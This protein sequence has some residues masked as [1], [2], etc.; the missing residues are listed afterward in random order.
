MPSANQVSIFDI[1][2]PSVVPV[3]AR[4]QTFHPRFGWLKK[5][6]DTVKTDS[7]VF[8]KKNSPVVLG[9]GKNMVDAIK[10]W[11]IA[12]KLIQDNGERLGK[13]ITTD[14]GEQL[15]GEDGWDPY[16]EDPASLW[17]LHWYLL[18]PTSH[19]T[20]WYLL[21]NRFNQLEF[22]SDDITAALEKSRQDLFPN[23]K[24]AKGSLVKDANCILRMYAIQKEKEVNEDSID[25]PFVNLGLIEKIDG[26]RD[27]M[28]N[29]GQHPQLAPEI[30]VAVCL[31]YAAMVESAK[32]ISISRLLYDPGCPGVAFKLT[33][34]V[35]SAAI[36][37]VQSEF[38]SIQ[39]SDSSGLI[40]FSF[41]GDPTELSKQILDKYFGNR[42]FR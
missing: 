3:F 26:S 25:C 10:Y 36:E 1:N 29:V 9:V 13:Y 19:A 18:K 41:T 14:F 38:E 32:T 21:F 39:L 17:L 30:I 20:A 6:F 2:K 7:E 12:F 22:T 34:S 28:F 33:E 24:I 27:Y 40:L 5:G 16:L 37:S 23:S 31:E 35:L 8:K 4:H 15:L 42:S 11:C